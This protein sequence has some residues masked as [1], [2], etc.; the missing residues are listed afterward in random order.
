MQ[1]V[2]WQCAGDGSDHPLGSRSEVTTKTL[3]GIAKQAPSGPA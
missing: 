1:T 2:V 3:P